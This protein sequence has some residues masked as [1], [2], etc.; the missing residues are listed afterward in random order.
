MQ[1]LPS[2]IQFQKNPAAAALVTCLLENENQFG[3]SDAILYYSFPLY[4]DEDG[5]A[6]VADSVLLSPLHGVVVFALTGESGHL[7]GSELRHCSEVVDQIPS[8]VQSRLVKNKQLRE[9]PIRLSFEITPVVYAPFLSHKPDANGSLLVTSNE[10]LGPFLDDIRAQTTPLSADTFKEL[11]STIEGAKGLIRPK[12]RDLPTQD[13]SSKGK[14]AEI[15]EAAIT[16]F[17]Q[18]QKHGMMGQV[19]G[20]QRIRGLAGSGKTVVLAMRAAQTHLQYPDAKIA[21]TFSTKS[22]YQHVK[23]LITR[24]YRQFDDQDPDWE[25]HVHVLHGWGSSNTPGIYSVACE[26]HGVRPLSFQEASE[27]TFDDRF[28]Y[29]VTQLMDTAKISPIYDYVFVDE[30]QDFPTSFVRLCYALAKDGKFVLAYDDLQTIFQSKTPSTAEIFG[31]DTMGKPKVIFEEDIV[32][33]KCYRNPREVLV[34]AHALGF[35]IYGKRIVQM[36]ENRDHW[37]DIG[38]NVK[39]GDFVEGSQIVV[40]RPV[41]NSLTVISDRSGFDEIVKPSAF[42]NMQGEIEAVAKSIADDLTD[43]LQPEDVLVVSIDD[44]HAKEY[45]QGIE[46]ELH[47]HEIQCNNL[48]TDSFGIRDFSKQ[49]RVT[50]ST[51]H[52]AKGN[53]AFMVYVMGVDAVMLKPNVRNRDMLFTAMTRAKGWVRITG[54]GAGAKQCISELKHAKENFPALVF[55]YPGPEELKIMKRD[56]AEAADKK[57]K[58][59]RLIE[60]LE[61]DFSYQ[62]IED[63]LRERKKGRSS[64]RLKSRRGGS[65]DR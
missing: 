30:G 20:P 13:E 64:T 4:R 53:E 56:L 44:R 41:E 17:D 61:E 32:L 10:T 55:E 62:E 15:V 22:L 63:I 47:K 45:L 58:A 57:L 50:L 42:E 19:T 36:L 54:V 12:K 43:G 11:I 46:R 25:K 51:V 52:K 35:G 3:L 65:D 39:Q 16:L 38:Y 5:G 40:E 18:Q 7:S 26:K 21:Y 59:R 14:Q 60:Q 49:G 48:H 9:S 29:A 37:E 1:L 33:H 6:V 31:T 23:R 34:S 24:F 27:R 28:D 8:Y 2:R